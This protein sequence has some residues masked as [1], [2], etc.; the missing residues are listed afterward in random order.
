MSKYYGQE[1]VLNIDFFIIKPLGKMNCCLLL[2][3]FSMKDVK[4]MV[5]NVD[6]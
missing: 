4:I 6:L 5:K 3:Y 2:N 1:T